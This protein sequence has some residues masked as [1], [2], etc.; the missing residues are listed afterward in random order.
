MHKGFPVSRVLL[1]GALLSPGPAFTQRGTGS[2]PGRLS[3]TR[4]SAPL[5]SLWVPP[6]NPNPPLIF[7]A[8]QPRGA[9]FGFLIVVSSAG[10]LYGA[11]LTHSGY[12]SC[13]PCI[14]VA[15][16]PMFAPVFNLCG[17]CSGFLQDCR[18]FQRSACSHASPVPS[19]VLPRSIP[20]SV[21]P[22][23]PLRV[24]AFSSIL[25]RQP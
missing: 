11:G 15:I 18:R 25:V 2:K 20:P 21:H 13:G 22:E 17:S 24:F 14:P 10:L 16:A 1:V 9:G 12:G 6:G 7:P 8:F 19:P 4:V 3:S 23:S 5:F